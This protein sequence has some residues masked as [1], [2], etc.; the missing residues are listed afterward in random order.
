[1]QIRLVVANAA[2]KFDVEF[3]AGN[4]GAEFVDRT[5]DHF[6]WGLGKLNLILRP[7]AA[8]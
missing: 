3:P 8:A 1:M 7:R 6:T 5:V 2:S 4:D